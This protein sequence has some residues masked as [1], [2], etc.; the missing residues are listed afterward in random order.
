[1]WI[2]S[3]RMISGRESDQVVRSVDVLPH[4]RFA[5]AEEDREAAFRATA[6]QSLRIALAEQALY[7]TST[8]SLL[9]GSPL[10]VVKSAIASTL[11]DADPADVEQ[12]RIA[13]RNLPNDHPI[14]IV[15]AEGTPAALWAIDGHSGSVVGLLSDGSG[16]GSSADEINNTFDEIIFGLTMLGALSGN[17]I[18]SAW[19]EFE[20]VVVEKIRD[21]ALVIDSLD[22]TGGGA[23]LAAPSTDV[24]IKDFADG[25]K[26]LGRDELLGALFPEYGRAKNAWDVY[27]AFLDLL[28]RR[29]QRENPD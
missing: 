15:P 28:A 8:A 27:K 7:A 23:I 17:L 12:M 24:S 1:M 14:L 5:T 3:S 11:K 26:D 29:R 9:E 10:V 2:M 21:A 20:K 19:A 6:R 4:T 22:M 18:I 13:A 25:F 16:G